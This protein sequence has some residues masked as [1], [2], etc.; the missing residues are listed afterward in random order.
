M[1]LDF[2]RKPQG[3]V[4]LHKSGGGN[5]SLSRTQLPYENLS[6]RFL[7]ST[8]QYSQQYSSLYYVR[9]E[10]LGEAVL[11][12]ARAKWGGQL[13]NAQFLEA[14][15]KAK[16]GGECVVIGTLYKSMT[17]KP[18]VLHEYMKHLAIEGPMDKYISDS[19]TLYLEDQTARVQLLGNTPPVGNVTTGLIVAVR[20]RMS[21]ACFH[22]T[23]YC[24]AGAT[25][26][27]PG[28]APSPEAPR[29]VAFVSGLRFGDASANEVH[30]R[31]LHEYLLGSS[32]S[33][34]QKEQAS[35][36]GRLIVVG[37]T[38]AAV[39]TEG[40]DV[41]VVEQADGWLGEVSATLP[42]DVMPGATDPCNATLPQQPIHAALFPHS[43]R[44][45]D[46]FQS[47]TNP[48]DCRVG[49]VRIIGTSG[50][51]VR[52]LMAFSSCT[53]PLDALK[54]TVQARCLAPTAPDTMGC[55]PFTKSD[56]FCM[57]N[58]DT[59]EGASVIFSGGHDR[60]QY[61][62]LGVGGEGGGEGQGPL[63]VCVPD[64]S[65]EPVVV[66]VDIDTLEVDL[67]E[68]GA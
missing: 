52:D 55:Y 41:K 26:P 15:K 12:A 34:E 19:D 62:R 56:P 28:P 24:L 29:Y 20:G 30:L 23:D 13:S 33:A 25:S 40:F 37:D 67:V 36:I 6:K 58:Q 10:L 63:C 35:R 8:G 48:Y 2:L 68:F 9:L 54:L 31:L 53:T 11:R 59:G 51:P 32:G 61:E 1:G 39:K 47:V 16:E 57:V 38:L 27:T 50:Q 3:A 43:R 42:V 22:A 18:S 64:F 7:V 60:V 14:L 49:G 65:V 17:L 66:L 4:D 5:P 21:D 45:A 44:Q 46:T